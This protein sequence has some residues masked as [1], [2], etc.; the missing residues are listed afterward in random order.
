MVRV[1]LINPA[2][3]ADQHLIAEYNEILMLLG[4]VRKHPNV[5]DIPQEYILGPGH[6]KFFKNKL[7]YLKERHELIKKEMKKRSFKTDKVID[8]KEFDKSL[9]NRWSPSKRDMDIIKQ[10]I[11]EKIRKKP[12]YY[13]HYG[14][15]KDENFLINLIEKS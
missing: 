9:H 6:I 14:E 2:H 5:K 13:R 8:L 1:N 7:I 12:G 11:K 10:R 15:K 3:L 4:Y